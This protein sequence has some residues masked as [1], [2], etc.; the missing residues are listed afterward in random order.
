[1]FNGAFSMV[2]HLEMNELNIELVKRYCEQ[3]LLPGFEELFRRVQIVQTKAEERFELLEPWIQWPT[4]YSGKSQSEHG[5]FRLGDVIETSHEQIFEKVERLT[6][7]AVV[8][9]SPMNALNRL[10]HEDSIFL[11]DPWTA[12]SVKAGWLLGRFAEIAKR[13]VNENSNRR[14]LS[15]A[16]A[17]VLVG[18]ALRYVS[19][20][21]MTMLGRFMFLGLRKSW[22]RPLILDAL[23]VTVL[24]GLCKKRDPVLATVFMNAGA[25]LQHHYLYSSAHYDGSNTNPAWFIDPKEDPVLCAYQL[26]DECI[27][28]VLRTFKDATLMLS[29]GLSQVPNPVEIHYY[30]PKKH[31]Q[32]IRDL[33]VDFW[34]ALE[35][36][37]SRDFLLRFESEKEVETARIILQSSRIIGSGDQLLF[38]DVRKNSIFVKTAFHGRPSDTLEFSSCKGALNFNEYFSHVTIENGVHVKVGYHLALD[39]SGAVSDLSNEVVPLTL[40]HERIVAASELASSS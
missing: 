32:L 27:S 40:I 18:V 33:G 21:T 4:V 28:K 17:L 7:R 36:R 19:F 9:L 14:S 23:L 6:G 37:M 24:I 16:D 15:V 5:I 22:A 12:S 13:A 1:M 8:A 10:T 31:A 3:G 20:S 26:Y 35:P 39:P 11:P 38:L 34:T 2:I 30:R 25:H 29:T